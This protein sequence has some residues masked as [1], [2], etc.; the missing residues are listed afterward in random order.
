MCSGK[1]KTGMALG[2][3]GGE[4]MGELRKRRNGFETGPKG[5][6]GGAWSRTGARTL[7]ELCQY[8]HFFRG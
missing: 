3:Q 1:G 6:D 2:A 7:E 5:K 8:I 4:D